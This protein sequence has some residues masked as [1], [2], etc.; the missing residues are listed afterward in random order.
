MICFTRSAAASLSVITLSF[1]NPAI[2]VLL[3]G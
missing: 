2:F 1:L 3:L